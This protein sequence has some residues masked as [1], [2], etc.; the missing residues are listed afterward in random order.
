MNLHL[1]LNLKSKVKI[2]LM[3]SENWDRYEFI[4]CPFVYFL[5]CF[6]L[7]CKYLIEIPLIFSMG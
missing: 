1:N 4:C 7:P 2:I 5:I 3:A 6:W